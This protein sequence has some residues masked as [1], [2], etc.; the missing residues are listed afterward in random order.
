[1]VDSPVAGD[2]RE[3]AGL[4]LEAFRQSLGS[5]HWLLDAP[6]G[7]RLIKR[8]LDLAHDDAVLW[9]L[10]HPEQVWELHRRDREAGAQALLTNTFT[11]CENWLRRSGRQ[12]DQ[13]RLIEAA[14]ALAR[15]AAEGLAWVLGSIGPAGNARECQH[16]AGLLLTSGVDAL[17]LETQTYQQAHDCLDL[18]ANE[19]TVPLL[20]SLHRWPES[21]ADAAQSLIDLGADALGVNCGTNLDDAWRELRRLQS[22]TSFP[23]LFKP[24][25]GATDS[26]ELLQSIATA[27]R[28]SA[29]RWLGVCCG[30]SERELK[31]ARAAGWGLGR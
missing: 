30:G 4:I 17:I 10:D 12:G 21:I 15:S 9:C 3:S 8:G 28:P 11:A 2:R 16:L 23:L 20:V 18:L 1:M 13:Q 19:A 26:L 31:C 29:T 27:C 24:A 14:V 6:M 25:I 22:V 7:T 5:G